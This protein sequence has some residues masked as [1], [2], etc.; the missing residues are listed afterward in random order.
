MTDISAE[1]LASFIDATSHDR[2]QCLHSVLLYIEES[3]D[4]S[5]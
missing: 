4:M 5:Q 3:S 1:R 2:K